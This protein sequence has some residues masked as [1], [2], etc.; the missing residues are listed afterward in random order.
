MKR[1]LYLSL[2]LLAV[3]VPAGAQTVTVQVDTSKVTSQIPVSTTFKD[4]AG[5]WW[6]VSGTLTVKPIPAP[7]VTGELP[8]VPP[9]P[10][11]G[12]PP[13]GPFPLPTITTASPFITSRAWDGQTFM[14]FGQNF[15]TDKGYLEL[16]YL[17][18]LA[19]SWSDRLIVAPAAKEPKLVLVQR[20]DGPYYLSYV[21]KEPSQPAALG[22]VP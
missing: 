20:T 11:P 15:G 17:P 1:L 3:A 14:L 13:P 7:G 12:P 19:T 21:G 6:S 16:S 5:V 22:Q 9:L 10:E 18:T 2:L 8:P 4:A